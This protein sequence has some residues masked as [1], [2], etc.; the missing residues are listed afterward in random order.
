M[1]LCNLGRLSDWWDW[2]RGWVHVT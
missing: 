2:V 1:N